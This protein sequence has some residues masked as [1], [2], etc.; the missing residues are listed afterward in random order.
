MG[1]L[2]L[3]NAG[4]YKAAQH[5]STDRT[6]GHKIAEEINRANKALIANLSSMR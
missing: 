6:L 5:C 1:P 3:I 4:W 2:V